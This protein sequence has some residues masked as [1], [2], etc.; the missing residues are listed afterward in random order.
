MRMVL[1]FPGKEEYHRDVNG[2]RDH[3][4]RSDH[5]GNVQAKLDR[6]TTIFDR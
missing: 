3:D 5:H 1:S 6:R 2:L 4:H